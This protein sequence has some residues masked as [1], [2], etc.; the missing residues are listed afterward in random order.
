MKQEPQSPPLV[1]PTLPP[2]PP[3][4]TKYTS[5]SL[6]TGGEDIN[7]TTCDG[8]YHLDEIVGIYVCLHRDG[9]NTST[10]SSAMYIHSLFPSLIL[11]PLSL[12]CFSL[13]TFY[14]SYIP[15][16]FPRLLITP[17]PLLSSLLA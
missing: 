9:V 16:S 17:S 10:P 5:G 4:R 11:T 6:V 3:H 2:S 15:P 14:L 1:P 13:P 12:F 8:A 7:S